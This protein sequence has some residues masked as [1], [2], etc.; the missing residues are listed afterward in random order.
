VAWNSVGSEQSSPPLDEIADSI[1]VEI[2]RDAI[3]RAESE[4]GAYGS[5]LPEQLLSLGQALQRQGRHEEALDLFK[6]GAHVARINDGLYSRQQVPLLHGE[7]SSHIALGQLAEA[8]ERQQALYRVQIRSLDAGE[9]R[10]QALMQQAG[11][12]LNAYQAGLGNPGFGR[13]LNMWDLYRLALTDI[14]ARDGDTSRQLLPPLYGMLRAQYLIAG[15]DTVASGG[16]TGTGVESDYLNRQEYNRFSAYRSQSFDKGS[17]VIR[18]IYEIEQEQAEVDR[19]ASAAVL[20]QLGDWYLIHGEHDSA[21]RA[22]LDAQRELVERDDA[23]QQIQHL[24]GEPIALPSLAGVRPLPAV[25]PVEQAD[26]VLEFDVTKRGRVV[27]LE[28]LDET[29]GVS[30]KV[31]RLMRQLRKTP[32]RPR[33]DS[34]EPVDT[35]KVVRAYVIAD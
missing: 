16:G 22:Y 14:A 32:F 1:D 28:R 30:G 17:A 15:Y 29:E 27:N 2:Y 10:A 23:Q 5:A 13:L 24:F 3:T 21:E 7:I 25:A 12:Q 6:R 33:F 31:N 18:A 8:D 20:A 34:G 11:W 19:V 35:E 9:L 4:F 26:L